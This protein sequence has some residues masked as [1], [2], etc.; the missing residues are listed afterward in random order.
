[1]GRISPACLHLQLFGGSEGDADD[2]FR[3]G[4]HHPQAPARF[5]LH[6]VWR[7]AGRELEA[8]RLL[9]AQELVLLALQPGELVAHPR[10]L[11]AD[12]GDPTRQPTDGREDRHV[13]NHPARL[14]RA[15]KAH[16]LDPLVH[17]RST[18]RSLALRA[19]GFRETSSSS[20]RTTLRVSSF[21][22]AAPQPQIGNPGGQRQ[23]CASSAKARLTAR[24]SSEWKEITTAR[25]PFARRLGIA[26]RNSSSA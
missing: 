14:H 7:A 11:H 23:G 25:P 19:L 12:E 4:I 10:P 22:S 2:P 18:A 16:P 8:K 5:G 20:G 17:S 9:L 13:A 24:S 6:V 21:H 15:P 1:S 3:G 26:S